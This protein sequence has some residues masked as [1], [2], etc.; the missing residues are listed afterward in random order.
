MNVARVVE[1]LTDP[2]STMKQ[3]ASGGFDVRDDEVQA[4]GGA[5]VRGGD[6]PAEDD[7]AAGTRRGEL[8]DAPVAAREVR[9]EPPAQ[10]TIEALGALDIRNRDHDHLQ[11]H[12]DLHRRCG[13]DLGWA[14]HIDHGHGKLL[15]LRCR[16]AS[17]RAPGWDGGPM[18][19]SAHA[20]AVVR[21]YR[22]WT[23]RAARP[24][25]LYRDPHRAER[26]SRQTVEPFTCIPDAVDAAIQT[27]SMVR[28][29]RRDQA[30]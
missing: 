8:D 4:L 1:H 3:L 10:L 24:P 15:G 26:R 23:V 17:L 28:P 2:H 30:T 29:I 11:F 5:R 19:S 20:V 7:G 22:H 6:V 9:I 21:S 14:A 12:G 18:R 25:G 16:R 27:R 13:L